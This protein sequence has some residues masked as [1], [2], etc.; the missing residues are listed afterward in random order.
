MITRE[1]DYALRL[2]RTLRDG[3]RITAAEAAQREMVPL[4]FAHKILK[5]LSK[6]GFVDITRGA[7]GGCRLQADLS[8][9]TLYDLMVAMEED[10]CL[11]SCMD[12]DYPCAWRESHGG[13]ALHCHLAGIQQRLN[14]ELR[15]H[16]LEEIFRTED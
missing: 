4:P 7:E 3:K 5:K 8:K 15:S 2:L 16:S 13:C 11:N 1:T 14:E 12:P 9:Y 6:M 10:C